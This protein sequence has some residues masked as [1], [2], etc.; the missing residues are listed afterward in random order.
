DEKIVETFMQV[1]IAV[2]PFATSKHFDFMVDSQD[3]GA[4]SFQGCLHLL[5]KLIQTYNGSRVSVLSKNKE[6]DGVCGYS[7]DL[8]EY[9]PP[10][11][12]QPIIETWKRNNGSIQEKS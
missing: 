12:I 9:E 1:I 5:Q 2:S 4:E 6:M 10:L 3:V 8:T 7:L 11:D